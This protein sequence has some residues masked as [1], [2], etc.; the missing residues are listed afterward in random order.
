MGGSIEFGDDARSDL[1]MIGD[2]SVARWDQMGVDSGGRR[3][4]DDGDRTT[5]KVIDVEGVF[6]YIPMCV[7][8]GF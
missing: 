5:E 6:V 8:I 3:Q 4:V 7:L 2:D 1:S